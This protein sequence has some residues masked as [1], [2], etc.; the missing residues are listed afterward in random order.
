MLK[1]VI[2]ITAICT[3]T[4]AMAQGTALGA[5]ATSAAAPGLN[6]RSRS[7]DAETRAY[8]ARRDNAQLEKRRRVAERRA[9]QKAA[10]AAEAATAQPGA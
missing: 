10:K 7:D 4:G 1:T 5:A 3:A 2:V 6:A 8:L 9:T